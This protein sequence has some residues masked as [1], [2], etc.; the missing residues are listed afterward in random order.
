MHDMTYGQRFLAE[1]ER[2]KLGNVIP[3]RM[4]A[5]LPAMAPSELR[6]RLGLPGCYLTMAQQAGPEELVHLVLAA[7]FR[8]ARKLVVILLLLFVAYP[9]MWAVH[10]L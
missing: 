8:A 3:R 5:Q 1:I 9:V 6:R 10:L 7:R 4:R 2:L